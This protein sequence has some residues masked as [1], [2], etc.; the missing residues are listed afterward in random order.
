M[1]K[2]LEQ[3]LRGT[4]DSNVSF[5]EL[6]HLLQLVGFTL[7]T[8]GSHHIFTKSGIE[9]I[10]NLQPQALMPNRIRLNRLEM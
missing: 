5:S 6:C 10:L 9:E 3:V 7:R 1:T 2:S 4:S 8:K